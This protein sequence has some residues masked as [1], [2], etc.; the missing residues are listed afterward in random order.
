VS[1][2]FMH[3]LPLSLVYSYIANIMGL[4]MGVTG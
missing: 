4:V 3:I 2:P 1:K